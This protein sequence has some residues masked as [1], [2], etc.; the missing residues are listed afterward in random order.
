[1]TPKSSV[2]RDIDQTLLTAAIGEALPGAAARVEHHV[3]HCVSCR[4]K[5]EQYRAVDAM[6]GAFGRSPVSPRALANSRRA[7]E[8]RVPGDPAYCLPTCR[9]LR[10][11]KP[12]RLMLFAS[13]QHA[14][15]AGLRP[16]ATCHPEINPISDGVSSFD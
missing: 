4:R 16:C 6:V 15:A 10:R 11:F 14:E 2:C 9:S 7:L 5:L 13:R 3:A 8:L 1:M 12:G